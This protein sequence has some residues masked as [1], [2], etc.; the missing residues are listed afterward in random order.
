MKAYVTRDSVSAGDDYN[1]PHELII[2]IPDDW[3]LESLVNEVWKSS[4]LPNVVGGR[5]TWALSS[6]IPLAV[7]AQQWDKLTLI[8]QLDVYRDELDIS[9]SEIRLHWSYFAQLDPDVVLEVLRR[10]RLR[11]L[12]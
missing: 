6:K 7:M 3:S 5:A 2:S 11:A 9:E 10:L 4:D 12:E 8:V 1:A